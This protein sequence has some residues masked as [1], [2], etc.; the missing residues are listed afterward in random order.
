MEFAVALRCPMRH[1]PLNCWFGVAMREMIFLTLANHLPR[2]RVMDRGRRLLL[3]LAGMHIPG[4][5][6]IWAP[7]TIRPVGGARRIEIGTDSFVNSGVR[8]GVPEAP[9]RIGARCRIGPNV[10]FET[11]SHGLYYV[12]GI[13]RGDV[14]APIIV[15]DEVWIAAGAIITQGVTIGRGA[16]VAA[17]AV[18]TKDVPPRTLV[19]GIPAKIIRELG[20]EQA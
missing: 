12:P 8:F 17:G 4:R 2:L 13:G 14:H 5:A 6:E 18:V 10:S 16:V 9:V 11:V 7:L 15:E 19:G 1:G 20:P 3:R